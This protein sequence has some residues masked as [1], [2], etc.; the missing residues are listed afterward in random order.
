MLRLH[1]A[2]TDLALRTCVGRWVRV[3]E[4]VLALRALRSPR[5]AAPPR[6]APPGLGAPGIRRIRRRRVRLTCPAVAAAVTV[7]Q[8]MA[9]VRRA[10]SE[11]LTRLMA[12]SYD[13]A[14]APHW[15]AM[16]AYLDAL[17]APTAPGSH[18]WPTPGRPACSRRC[19]P[20]WAGRSGPGG[21]RQPAA[22][23]ALVGAGWRWCRWCLPGRADRGGRDR[24]RWAVA[25]APSGRRRR[26]RGPAVAA[27]PGKRSPAHGLSHLLG[28]TR[29]GVLTAG[30][31]CTTSELARRLGI[32]AAAEPARVGAAAR[33]PDPTPLRLSNA[34]TC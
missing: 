26:H 23:Y 33:R 13:I 30:R 8:G 27:L 7:E 29:A 6:V 11:R 34:V 17:N 1:L 31:A 18:P 32:S 2:A 22:E 10:G 24:G 9:V 28:Q 20:A 21:G 3:A 16:R 12:T 25:G 19:I 5:D 15:P 4:T 14:L